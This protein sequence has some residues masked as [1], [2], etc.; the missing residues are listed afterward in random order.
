LITVNTLLTKENKLP[1]TVP[2]EANKWKFAISVFVCSK[3]TE[4]AVFR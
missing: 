3:K 4:V 2:F 1:F